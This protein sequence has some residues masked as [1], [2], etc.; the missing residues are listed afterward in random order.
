MAVKAPSIFTFFLLFIKFI[1]VKLQNEKANYEDNVFM[2]RMDLLA[3]LEDAAV[4]TL[5]R[6]VVR[7]EYFRVPPTVG[8]IYIMK[9]L[10]D[11]SISSIKQ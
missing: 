2:L 7:S 1:K 6:G 8:A 11:K 10:L 9:I 5:K 4:K 3:C